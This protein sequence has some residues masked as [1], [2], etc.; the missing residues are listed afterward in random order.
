MMLN[1]MQR[2][3][4]NSLFKSAIQSQ[5]PSVPGATMA[6]GYGATNAIRIEIGNN[7]HDKSF[8]DDYQ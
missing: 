8:F 6:S 7:N 1:N 2:K 4:I 3:P 5:R